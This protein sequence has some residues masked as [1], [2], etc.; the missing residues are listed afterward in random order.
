MED[1]THSVKSIIVNRLDDDSLFAQCSCVSTKQEALAWIIT[2]T[3]YFRVKNAGFEVYRSLKERP[4]FRSFPQLTGMHAYLNCGKA[5][6]TI[7]G[8]NERFAWD[9]FSQCI[10]G[11]IQ[12][13]AFCYE[14]RG[15]AD[16]EAYLNYWNKLYQNGCY[17]FTHLKDNKNSWFEYIG[18]SPRQHNL[19]N[20]SYVVDINNQEYYQQISGT[21]IDSYHEINIQLLCDKS[22][23]V[24]QCMADPVR[25]PDDM[26]K[27][28]LKQ[29]DKII[30]QNILL[31][32][33][34]E[35][36]GLVGGMEG[37]AHLADILN[38]VHECLSD[39]TVQVEDFN[40]TEKE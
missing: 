8:Q 23:V 17:K 2:D 3:R 5:W 15:F 30:G 39:Q 27:T 1:H 10:K 6:K 36:N 13:E 16:R 37:C 4:G 25:I 34:K 22:N 32:D 33:K 20:R 18:D 40:S 31:L 21:I 12:S 38:E 24:F 9:L 29:I 14:E 19:F 35:M 11:I 28:G 7:L 26:C